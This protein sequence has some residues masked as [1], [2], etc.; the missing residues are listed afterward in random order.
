MG[1]YRRLNRRAPYPDWRQW[2]SFPRIYSTTESS[3]GGSG[4]QRTSQLTGLGSAF[5]SFFWC[6][7]LRGMDIVKRNRLFSLFDSFDGVG[8]IGSG[9]GNDVSTVPGSV[10]V[11]GFEPLGLTVQVNTGRSVITVTDYEYVIACGLDGATGAMRMARHCFGWER[12]ATDRVGGVVPQPITPPTPSMVC[13]G[14]EWGLFSGNYKY[15]GQV[16][17]T[18]LH[19][20]S[21]SSAYVDVWDKDVQ[22]M[23]LTDP[24]TWTFPSPLVW[25]QGNAAHW[26]SGVN[27]GTG[28]NFFVNPGCEVADV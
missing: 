2:V 16:A 9:V 7:R 19:M 20:A 3:T 22:A 4:L 12:G 18:W 8:R 13:T 1:R 25:F 23:L 10:G 17:F 26:N 15:S 6:V 14:D 11:S 5:T 21:D 28:G 24:T 27:R